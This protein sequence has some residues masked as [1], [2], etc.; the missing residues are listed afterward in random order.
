MR[1]N[2]F[3]VSLGALIVAPF[4]PHQGST[5]AKRPTV[6][7]ETTQKLHTW[8]PNIMNDEYWVVFDDERGIVRW[9]PNC[10]KPIFGKKIGE[11]KYAL[12]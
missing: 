9:T 3:L 8:Y 1:R 7:H 2:E 6:G 4:L 12:V 5:V 11:H 10:E